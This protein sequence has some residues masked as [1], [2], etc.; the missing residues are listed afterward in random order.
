MV[1]FTLSSSLICD[2]GHVRARH[3]LHRRGQGQ[4]DDHPSGYAPGGWGFP[5]ISGHG[6]RVSPAGRGGLQTART[7]L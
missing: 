5:G 7:A 3:V 1:V 4:R 6:C 2:H